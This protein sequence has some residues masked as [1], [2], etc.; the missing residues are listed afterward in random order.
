MNDILVFFHNHKHLFVVS[1]ISALLVLTFQVIMSTLTHNQSELPPDIR[2]EN[3][4]AEVI[5]LKAS[6]SSNNQ[7]ITILSK[8]ESEIFN[9][10]GWVSRTNLHTGEALGPILIERLHFS[11]SDSEIHR[12]NQLQFET[13]LRLPLTP[14]LKVRICG[15]D[16][17]A[18]SCTRYAY[19]QAGDAIPILFTYSNKINT[20]EA[21]IKATVLESTAQMQGIFLLTEDLPINIEPLL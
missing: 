19:N 21:T 17:L 18:N 13:H 14:L 16:T 3:I 4:Q 6:S 5:S 10:Q 9:E 2:V 1:L 12:G 11:F 8:Q 15:G 7:T 20:N